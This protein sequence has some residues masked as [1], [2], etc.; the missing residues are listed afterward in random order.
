MGPD[1]WGGAR[2]DALYRE[3][4]PTITRSVAWIVGDA[5]V[6]REIAQDAFVALLVHWRKVSR[7]DNP[8]AW[9]RRVAI[10]DAIRVAKRDGTRP[11]F[12]P[13]ERA[14][15]TDAASA[16]I[17]VWRAVSTL[18]PAQRAAVVLHY[19]HDLPVAEVA[20]TLGCS[21]G[22]AKTHLSRARHTLAA[23][24]GEERD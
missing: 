23:R 5:E 21:E 8:G 14:V 9:A 16:A 3:S 4:F 17:D 7:Y 24:L 19:L 18:P 6:A 22:T 13:S 20:T 10:R 11:L 12:P 15:E 2:F 1:R